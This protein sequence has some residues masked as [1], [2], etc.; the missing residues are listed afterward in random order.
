MNVEDKVKE[1]TWLTMPECNSI[2]L[3]RLFFFFL[4][5]WNRLCS[6]ASSSFLVLLLFF[7]SFFFFPL[8]VLAEVSAVF[9]PFL[10][11]VSKGMV[12]GLGTSSLASERNMRA[13]SWFCNKQFCL[14]STRRWGSKELI[15][16]SKLKNISSYYKPTILM[17]AYLLY[18]ATY[19]SRKHQKSFWAVTFGSW[20]RSRSILSQNHK[21]SNKIPVSR[22]RSSLS[23]KKIK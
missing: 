18:Q 12:P 21:P 8:C 16:Q 15:I 1:M 9:F 14:R 6:K 2:Y 4:P 17:L 19:L 23:I 7:F 5:Y 13:H 10:P 3:P 20:E 11:R 22:C